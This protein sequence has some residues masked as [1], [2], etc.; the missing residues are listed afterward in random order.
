MPPMGRLCEQWGETLQRPVRLF[1][2][3]R[4]GWGNLPEQLLEL[5]HSLSTFFLVPGYRAQGGGARVTCC[6]ALTPKG[7]GAVINA[8]RSI[9]CAWQKTEA[10]GRGLC[11][12]GG[13]GA[14]RM[15]DELVAGLGGRIGA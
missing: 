4:R 9:L 14:R 1:R 12:G 15:R 10:K 13:A 6:P 11:S 8:S 7:L 3:V 2:F 5:R